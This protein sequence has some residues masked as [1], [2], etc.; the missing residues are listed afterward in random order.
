MIATRART[1]V[2]S[3]PLNS[4]LGTFAI[5][6]AASFAVPQ[7]A[8]AVINGNVRSACMSDYFAYCAGMEVGSS[9]LRRCMNRA[10]PR[11]T[12]SCV[13]A[14]VAAGEVS[15]AEVSRRSGATTRTA[16]KKGKGK[17]K[18]A[19]RQFATLR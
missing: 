9:E 1:L 17:G 3:L 16:S 12:S 4:L 19:K 7:P 8:S 11:L 2:R 15:R 6:A 10:G 14:L 18:S 5:V 13:N